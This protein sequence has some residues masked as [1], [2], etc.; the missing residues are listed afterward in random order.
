M[1]RSIE[2]ATLCNAASVRDDLLSLL[3]GGITTLTAEQFPASV[4]L[5][6]VA[7][8]AFTEPDVGQL[9]TMG[10]DVTGD[11]KESLVSETITVTP[12][13]PPDADLAIPY[14]HT[15]L[16]RLGLTFARPGV[17]TV[18]VTMNG[19]PPRRLPLRVQA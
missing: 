5:T 2:L 11:E 14:I 13:R 4:E 17:Y 16:H 9:E 7:Q 15:W 6:L 8:F 18:T 19:V 10:L 3:D 1:S 12:Q